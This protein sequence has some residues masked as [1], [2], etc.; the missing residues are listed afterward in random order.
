[1]FEWWHVVLCFVGG[2]IVLGFIAG[3]YLN[4]NQKRYKRIYKEEKKD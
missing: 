4:Q 2:S 1:M 3:P